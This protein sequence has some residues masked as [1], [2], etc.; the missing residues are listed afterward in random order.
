MCFHDCSNGA[1]DSWG[2]LRGMPS[3][4]ICNKVDGA[5]DHSDEDDDG[6]EAE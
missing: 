4:T 5:A 3:S 1:E 2:C 6:E